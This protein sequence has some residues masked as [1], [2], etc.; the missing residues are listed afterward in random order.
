MAGRIGWPEVVHSL[1]K[2]SMGKGVLLPFLGGLFPLLS[3][4]LAVLTNWPLWF[5]LSLGHLVF[6]GG[7]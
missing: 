5:N 4:E 1:G 6:C 7:Q 2:L 3:Q